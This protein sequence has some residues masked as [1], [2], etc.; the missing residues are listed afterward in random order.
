MIGWK[1]RIPFIF[2]KPKKGK[3]K[4][5]NTIA[6]SYVTPSVQSERMLTSL[7]NMHRLLYNSIEDLVIVESNGGLGG[8]TITYMRSGIVSKIYSTELDKKRFK[9]LEH[10]VSLFSG[11][12]TKLYNANFIDWFK[13]N[14]DKIGK[15]RNVCCIMDP[16]WGGLDYKKKEVIEDLYMNSDDGT[17]YGMLDLIRMVSDYV[18]IVA[19]KLPFNYDFTKFKENI[20]EY[21]V[22]HIKKIVFIIIDVR[23]LM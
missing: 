5:D 13:D 2:P 12:E 3:I 17:R 4:Y 14:A 6:L 8:D 18:N 19:L 16:P 15:L 21:Y 10:N 23:K 1:T 7:K 11:V 22:H 20:N 9:M